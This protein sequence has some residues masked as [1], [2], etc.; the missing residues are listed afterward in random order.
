MDFEVLI[1]SSGEQE[2]I[3]LRCKSDQ[4]LLQLFLA[5]KVNIDHSCGGHATCGT[6]KFKLI[7]G[8]LNPRNEE[9]LEI[10]R[11][12]S[13]NEYERLSC[14]SIPTSDLVIDLS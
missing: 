3:K 12:R 1:L 11:D 5:N 6:C 14:Q 10:Y 8:K 2:N 4:N 13:L 9:E 7:K